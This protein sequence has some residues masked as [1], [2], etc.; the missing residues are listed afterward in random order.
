VGGKGG[1]FA[2]IG[3][4]WHGTL[5]AR[6]TELRM[7]TTIAIIGGR[8]YTGGPDDYAAVHA[9]QD[10]L[11]LIPLSAWG[12]DYKPPDNVHLKPGVE[13]APVGTQVMTL[14][15]EAFFNGLNTLLPQ[16]PPEPADRELM[17]RLAKLG[18]EPGAAFSMSGFDSDVRTAIEEG[19]AT[20]KQ[21]IRDE[22][23]KLGEQVNGWVSRAT[24][25]VTTP[26]THIARPGRSSASAAT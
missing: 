12:T 20:G 9:L 14:S 5:P 25:V 23:P 18:I 26:S 1:D 17:A 15:V 22:E 3:P 2:I 19:V 11:K 13:E 16:N 21:A 8:I 4:G 6:V 7:P 10:Q 24:W